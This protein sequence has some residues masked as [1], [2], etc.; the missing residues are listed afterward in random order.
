MSHSGRR[1]LVTGAG[2]GI[3][4]EV[5]RRLVADGAEVVA[6]SRDA[7]DLESLAAETGCAVVVAD[8]ADLEGAVRAVEA[9]LPVDLL[10][11]NAGITRLAP[12]L[13]IDMRDVRAVLEVN[14]VA[15]LRLAQ[16]VAGDLV[17]RGRGG[18]IVNVS[19]VAAAIGLAEHSGDC[20][21]KAGLDAVTRV[22]AVELGP[23]GIRVN[24]V[25]PFITLT[26]MGEAAWSDPGKA[27]PMLARIP[28]RRF[29]T[30]GDVAAVV[31]FL[32]GE[33]AAMVNGASLDVDGGF[34]IA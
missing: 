13:T 1:A 10:V 9:V 24:S 17:R 6:L 29:C 12:A 3:G 7:A 23:L 34:R 27:A 11:N 25:N 4:R 20:A 32:L 22:L 14:T 15:P 18:A 5:V 21:A 26:P 28:A 30:P 31:S 19:S 8:L 16:V 33:D 2:K